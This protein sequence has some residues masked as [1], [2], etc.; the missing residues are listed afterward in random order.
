[1]SEK[2]NGLGLYLEKLTSS[3]EDI[4]CVW[5]SGLF[6]RLLVP[7]QP[8]GSYIVVAFDNEAGLAT[9]NSLDQFYRNHQLLRCKY[10]V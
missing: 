1:M 10:C 6:M 4:A 8:R 3:L 5:R 9:L 7:S 2:A